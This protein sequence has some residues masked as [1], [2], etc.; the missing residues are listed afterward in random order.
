[1]EDLLMS[2]YELKENL[3]RRAEE[4]KAQLE[5]CDGNMS[6]T[7]IQRRIKLLMH[8]SAEAAE[9]IADIRARL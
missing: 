9:T 4:L 5:L 2:Y 8:E 1:M 6:A 7:Y 3:D